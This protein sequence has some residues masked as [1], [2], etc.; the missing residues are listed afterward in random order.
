MAR[1]DGYL[2]SIE[3]FG[4][5]GA[6]LISGQSITL[7][8]PAGDRQAT[9][10]TA[11][12]QLVAMVR[13]VAPIDA[14][15]MI[16]AGRPARFVFE[17]GT[18]SYQAAI[19]IATSGWT[20]ALTPTQSPTPQ[21]V[22]SPGPKIERT[23]ERSERG[24]SVGSSQ[25]G[26]LSPEGLEIERSQYDDDSAVSSTSGSVLLDQLFVAARTARASDL[27][28]SADMTPYMRVVGEL[29]SI[30]GQGAIDA[31]R[32]ERELG[33]VAPSQQRDVAA[34]GSAASFV[35]SNGDVRLR[36]SMTRDVRG[37]HAAVRFLVAEPP[38][39]ERLGM[40]DAVTNLL[41]AAK[42]GLFVVTGTP[43]SGKT[44]ALAAL[45]HYLNAAG[46]RFIVDLAHLIEIAQPVRTGLVSQRQIGE[47]A[48]SYGSGIAAA[49]R[50][51]ADVIVISE[52]NDAETARAIV[53]AVTAGTLV[54]VAVAADSVWSGVRRLTALAD[55]GQSSS[56]LASLS[57][58]FSGG[59][60]SAL[61]RKGDSGRIA[62]YE[63]IA[64]TDD[65]RNSLAAGNLPAFNAAV[66]AAGP[67]GAIS[68]LQAVADVAGRTSKLV[69]R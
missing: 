12:D 62:A 57:S 10:V 13:E 25:I 68:M 22:V 60:A 5:A 34:M 16:D 21:P 33:V 36:I 31:N 56:V 49:M 50:E 26:D 9:Q 17:S 69:Q 20:V 66:G 54:I 58:H 64:P 11:H 30:P 2:R 48:T 3:R 35:Y 7:K 32:L 29:V 67:Q 39:P 63:V 53:G 45:V 40:P 41:A 8:F 28:L 55:E 19:T 65:I 47:H 43:G 51:A 23:S 14:L 1:I 15:Q 46:G 61:L 59:I 24:V 37:A 27:Y 42:R 4:A 6:V 18:Y 52:C 44:T 38:M